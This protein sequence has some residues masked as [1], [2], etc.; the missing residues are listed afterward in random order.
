MPDKER[1]KD[2]SKD[3]INVLLFTLSFNADFG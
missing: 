1:R 3:E 2:L